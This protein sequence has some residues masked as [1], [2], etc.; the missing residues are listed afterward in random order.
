MT[1]YLLSI[2]LTASMSIK[3][4]D[5]TLNNEFNSSDI[6]LDCISEILS[7]VPG[8]DKALNQIIRQVPIHNKVYD[9]I[10]KAYLNKSKIIY[11]EESE[12]EAIIKNNFSTA[13]GKS[14][15]NFRKRITDAFKRYIDKNPYGHLLKY[16]RHFNA[17]YLDAALDEE[18]KSIKNILGV[19]RNAN[20]IL[21]I[22]LLPRL[23][24]NNEETVLLQQD[25]NQKEKL[26][27]HTIGYFDTDKITLKSKFNKSVYLASQKLTNPNIAAKSFYQ[28]FKIGIMLMTYVYVLVF[29]F[30]SFLTLYDSF[31]LANACS[32]LFLVYMLSKKLA[33]DISP[34]I[35]QNSP[36]SRINAIKSICLQLSYDIKLL[37]HAIR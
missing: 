11:I 28:V 25:L 16:I 34:T 10:V 23:N 7:F 20:G 18:F 33:A 35:I 13:H 32:I 26:L 37:K 6:N 24:L 12:I 4:A 15:E 31:R 3:A 19:L 29:V 14:S 1:K 30:S 27:D 22:N 2:L 36:V 9:T 17:S 5:N 8:Y 21:D